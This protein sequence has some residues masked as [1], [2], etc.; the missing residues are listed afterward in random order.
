MAGILIIDDTRE[1][2]TLFGRIL[3]GAGYTTIG[4]SSAQEGLAA[5]RRERPDVI[6]LDLRLPDLD[7]WSVAAAL[8]ADPHTRHIPILLVSA[9]PPARE[10]AAAHAADYD[11]LLIKPFAFGDFL[12]TVTRLLGSASEPADGASGER[13]RSVGS[14][15]EPVDL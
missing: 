2:R 8:K 15:D 1:H 6:V 5:A 14:A 11:A 4:A 12:A 7:G 9:T 13:R 10:Q 3:A